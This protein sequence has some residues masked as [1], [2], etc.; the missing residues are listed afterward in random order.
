MGYGNHLAAALGAEIDLLRLW[1]IARVRSA[2]LRDVFSDC[3]S[4][5]LKNASAFHDR[6]LYSLGAQG[7]ALLEE[8]KAARQEIGELAGRLLQLHG[9][10]HAKDAADLRTRLAAR[11]SLLKQRVAQL[12]SCATQLG[13]RIIALSADR[14]D[15]RFAAF[16]ERARAPAAACAAAYQDLAR[17]REQ[18]ACLRQSLGFDVRK[19]S[20]AVACLLAVVLTLLATSGSGPAGKPT[21][22]S[23]AAPPERLR[24]LVFVVPGT[25]GNDGFWPSVVEGKASF[26]SELLRSLGPGSAVRPFLWDGSN[27]HQARMVAAGDLAAAIDE[28]A[29]GYDR[30]C[31]VGHSHGGNIALAAAGKCRTKIDVLVCLSTPHVHVSMKGA[32]GTALY[33]PV[34]CGW[35]ARQNI[36]AIVSLS[37]QGDN[38]I[39]WAGVFRGLDDATATAMTRHWQE[40]LDYPRL[41]ADG[42]FAGSVLVT[43]PWL[44]AADAN[45]TTLSFVEGLENRHAA[46]HSRRMGTVV[47]RL[48]ASRASTEQVQYVRTLVEPRE[49][50]PGEPAAQG[51]WDAWLARRA[52][53][54]KHVGWRLERLTVHLLPEASRVA[55]NAE[56]VSPTP[57]VRITSVDGGFEH[58]RTPANQDAFNAAWETGFILYEGQ[59]AVLRAYDRHLLTADTDLGGRYLRAPTLNSLPMSK[60]LPAD[61]SLRVYWSAELNW[62]AMHY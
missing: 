5:A 9:Q 28:Q 4:F 50:D 35:E 52:P 7:A 58:W 12:K 42:P 51:E 14:E 37:V 29:L 8:V 20:A 10:S 30:V 39:D 1:W 34:Y 27:D 32:D 45:V 49:E 59:T 6:R 47:G 46:T 56:G 43:V 36:R 2:A 60:S 25:Y 41:A 53:L 38:V 22:P 57:Y 13:H 55:G 44:S 3:G 16:Y 48:L 15:P 11:R 54:F 26:G 40:H 23:G 21:G 33:V 31:L 61:A 18:R 19:A 17:L 62:V 24:T